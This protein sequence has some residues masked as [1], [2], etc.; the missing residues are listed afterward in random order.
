MS[1]VKCSS[2]RFFSFLI[3]LGLCLLAM[4][5]QT[6]EARRR[7]FFRRR[8]V[9]GRRCC[10]VP[11][12]R[13]VPCCRR[14]PSQFA[15]ANNN[16]RFN[17]FD[18]FDRLA[19]GRQAVDPF[20]SL[21]LDPSGD[22]SRLAGLSQLADQNGMRRIGSSNIAVNS[23]GEFFEQLNQDVLTNDRP[24]VFNDGKILGGAVVPL[25]DDTLEQ[26]RRLN[27]AGAFRSFGRRGF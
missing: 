9:F 2:W 16:N 21:A 19:L 14:Q 11:R 22:L 20:S 7:G 1:Q 26:V 25:R 27:A 3:L 5:E 23:R 17:R 18:D 15:R 6:A 10:S 8:A 12:R 24:L 13:A 4:T